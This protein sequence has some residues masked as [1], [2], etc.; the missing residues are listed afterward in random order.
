M[1]SGFGGGE[2]PT[3]ESALLQQAVLSWKLTGQRSSLS[4]FALQH[5]FS[6]QPLVSPAVM[7]GR[8]ERRRSHTGLAPVTSGL[9]RKK[10][11]LLPVVAWLE[12]IRVS[13]ASFARPRSFFSRIRSS[14]GIRLGS[15]LPKP[16]PGRFSLSQ[17]KVRSANG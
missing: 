16:S 2:Q 9:I 3:V 11:P 13:S 4:Y 14:I 12:G 7:I 10:E 17:K 1:E 5:R 8:V 6:R 15:N